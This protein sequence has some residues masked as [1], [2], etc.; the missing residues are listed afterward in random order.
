MLKKSL[1]IQ[2][3]LVN[4]AINIIREKGSVTLM[5]IAAKA[6][7]NIAAVN[8]HFKDKASFNRVIINTV[9]DEVLEWAQA[10]ERVKTCTSKEETVHVIIE[11]TMQFVEQNIGVFRYALSLGDEKTQDGTI[12]DVLIRRLDDLMKIV[13]KHLAN[14]LPEASTEQLETKYSIL[15]SG[16]MMPLIFNMSGTEKNR[17]YNNRDGYISV[18]MRGMFV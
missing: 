6:E 1:K 5:D 8:Y 18:M 16:Y 10:T 12:M 4:E 3:R 2:Q 15:F 17:Y 13:L 11:Y 9:F 14:V 7:C